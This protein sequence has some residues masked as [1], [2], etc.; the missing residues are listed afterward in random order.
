MAW[1]DT[2]GGRRFIIAS[3]T[4]LVCTLLVWFLK[5]PPDIFRDVVIATVA[6]YIGGRTY[7]SVKGSKDNGGTPTGQ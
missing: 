7:E 3:C 2:A 1:H 4:L 6:T 5:I